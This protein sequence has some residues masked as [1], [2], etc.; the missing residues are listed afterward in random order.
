MCQKSLKCI[1]SQISNNINSSI[2]KV[3]SLPMSGVFLKSI[4]LLNYLAFH[5]IFLHVPVHILVYCLIAND[6]FCRSIN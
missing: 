6:F 1:F 2:S 3:Y 4:Y 5:L